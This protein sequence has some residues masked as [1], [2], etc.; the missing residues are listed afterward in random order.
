M[1]QIHIFKNKTYGNINEKRC[2][3]DCV[4]DSF[5]EEAKFF[6]NRSNKQNVIS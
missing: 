1:I 2:I 6:H 3:G 4:I 5:L